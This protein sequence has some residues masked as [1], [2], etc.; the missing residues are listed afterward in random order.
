MLPV[1]TH[2]LDYGEADFGR[3]TLFV[4][5]LVI[6]GS[7]AGARYEQA[8]LLP[9]SDA[10]AINIFC[11][12]FYIALCTAATSALVIWLRPTWLFEYFNLKMLGNYIWLI[13]PSILAFAI[14]NQL[15]AWSNRIKRYGRISESMIGKSAVAFGTRYGYGATG[16]TTFGL[17]WG[18][19]WNQIFGVI[20]LLSRNWKSLKKVFTQIRHKKIK[21][22]AKHYHEFPSINVPQTLTTTLQ[23]EGITFIIAYFFDAV[24]LGLFGMALRLL[25]TP[26]AMIGTAVGKVFFQ[27]SSESVQNRSTDLPS[28]VLKIMGRMA[29]VGLPI[30]SLI[31]FLA[32]TAFAWYLGEEW[33]QAGVIAQII[34]PYLFLYFAIVPMA[35]LPMAVKEQPTSLMIEVATTIAKFLALWFGAKTGSYVT[36][37]TWFTIVSCITIALTGYWYYRIAHKLPPESYTEPT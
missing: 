16:Q 13:P 9:K 11:L 3:L 20:Y 26:V 22:L 32:P 15:Y 21:S 33:R 34:S 19:F 10:D 17:V 27:K 28:L 30:F 25:R 1:Y 6:L 29:L 2:V 5:I 7:L 35:Y 14:F 37:F 31:F 4:S 23:N 36:A 18:V 24:I 12:A 8:I